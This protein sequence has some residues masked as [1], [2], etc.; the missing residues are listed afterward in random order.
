MGLNVN[1]TEINEDDDIK[2]DKLKKANESRAKYLQIMQQFNKSETIDCSPS[3]TSTKSLPIDCGLRWEPKPITEVIADMV[4]H[5]IGTISTIINDIEI[6]IESDHSPQTV[7]TFDSVLCLSDHTA[8]GRVDDIFGAV[9][10]PHYF[11]RLTVDKAVALKDKLLP[12][13]DVFA[14]QS[15]TKYAIPPQTDERYSSESECDSSS[16]DGGYGPNRINIKEKQHKHKYP[17]QRKRT[18]SVDRS[19]NSQQNDSRNYR[20][21]RNAQSNN[22]K[23]RR[24]YGGNHYKRQRYSN[25]YVNMLNPV[26]YPPFGALPTAIP[27]QHVQTASMFRPQ[28]NIIPS[29]PMHLYQN[30]MMYQQQQSMQYS[31]PNSV[32][33]GQQQT[34]ANNEHKTNNNEKDNNSKNVTVS[35]NPFSF[36]KQSK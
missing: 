4:I 15:L 2:S 20:N 7:I 28:V 29:M 8:I 25:P 23:Q 22:Y 6:V 35:T 12:R 19:F 27:P 33:S 3:V 13:M 31:Q 9:K 10:K 11:V 21:R 34:S 18:M 30:A 16:S 5:K 36:G 32:Q 17:K 24:R 14:V 26:Y 1:Q